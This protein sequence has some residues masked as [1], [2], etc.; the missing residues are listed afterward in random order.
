MIKETKGIL[1]SDKKRKKKQRET[2][3]AEI[4]LLQHSYG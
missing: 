2:K 4:Y 1:Q 3:R